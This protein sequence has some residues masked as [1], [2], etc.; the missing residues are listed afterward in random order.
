MV[1]D[2]C[3][4]AMDRWEVI[5]LHNP[6]KRTIFVPVR[7]GQFF[8]KT[9]SGSTLQYNGLLHKRMQKAVYLYTYTL[10]RLYTHTLIFLYRCTS[11]QTYRCTDKQSYTHTSIWINRC[12][13]QTY[14]YIYIHL[15]V[16]LFIQTYIYTFVC[17][18][19]CLCILLYFYTDIHLYVCIFRQ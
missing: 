11:I 12:F 19:F 16:D 15:Q 2:S 6:L 10:I 18:L 7:N 3:W 1:Q 17:L 14:S 13:L 5:F 9:I 4:Q 8:N